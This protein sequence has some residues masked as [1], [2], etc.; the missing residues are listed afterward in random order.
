MNSMTDVPDVGSDWLD[1]DWVSEE[2]IDV[3]TVLRSDERLYLLPGI[4]C[5][6]LAVKYIVWFMREWT[7]RET[8]GV[9]QLKNEIAQ[10]KKQI[11]ALSP[12]ADFVR[13]S[14]L[15]RTVIKQEKK[16]SGMTAANVSHEMK[17]FALP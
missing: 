6:C 4:F 11:K 13:M 17:R 9:A 10:L 5:L 2:K 16:L 12:M 3:T 14:K 15:E 8:V 1:A 7:N